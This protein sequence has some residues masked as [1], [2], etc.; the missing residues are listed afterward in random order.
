MPN[1]PVLA[2]EEEE[3]EEE[4]EGEEE[5]EE[6]D[7]DDE[8]DVSGVR[9]ARRDLAAEGRIWSS[10]RARKVRTSTAS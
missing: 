5:D 8:E 4:E 3:E 10:R 6:D 7:D 2:C 1:R 9:V